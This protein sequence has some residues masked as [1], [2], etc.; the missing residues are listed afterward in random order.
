MNEKVLKECIDGL[1]DKNLINPV[2]DPHALCDSCRVAKATI[3]VHFKHGSLSFCTHHLRVNLRSI[4][5]QI[6]SD[7]DLT[8]KQLLSAQEYQKL[9]VEGG[10]ADAI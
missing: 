4:Y 5:A 8:L 2:D 3:Q 7:S 9:V 1:L 6:E 10:V